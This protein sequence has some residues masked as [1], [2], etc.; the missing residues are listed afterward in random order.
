MKLDANAPLDAWAVSEGKR[1]L[2]LIPRLTPPQK[3]NRLFYHWRVSTYAGDD[4]AYNALVA[5]INGQ[6]KIH[7]EA[8]PRLNAVDPYLPGAAEHTYRRNSNGL[9]ISVDAMLGAT[10]T[11]F[12]QYP[13]QVGQVWVMCA[14]G[15]AFALAYDIDVLALTPDER[16]WASAPIHT[17]MSHGEAAIITPSTGDDGTAYPHY[18]C[19][20]VNGVAGDPGCRWDLSLEDPSDAPLSTATCYAMGDKLRLI[21]HRLK[22][23]I[24]A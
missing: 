18:F 20:P 9:G 10:T 1:F 13:V 8:D 16:G 2:S 19:A 17:V 7:L 24:A 23:A 4:C 12:G 15:A 14:A 5:L 3:I 22:G 21:T 6:W 11:D